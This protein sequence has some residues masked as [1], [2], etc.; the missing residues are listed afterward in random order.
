ML[1]RSTVRLARVPEQGSEGPGRDRYGVVRWAGGESSQRNGRERVVRCQRPAESA[2]WT[3]SA[4]VPDRPPVFIVRVALYVPA[5]VFVRV[6]AQ[7]ET[8]GWVTYTRGVVDRA[9][10]VVTEIEIDRPRVAADAEGR[11]PKAFISKATAWVALSVP[12]VA[13]ATAV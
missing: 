10:A 7:V 8:P 4:T 11:I 12:S 9:S 6:T 3:F 1:G 13:V 5:E 2:A